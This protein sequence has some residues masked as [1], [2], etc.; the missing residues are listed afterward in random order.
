MLD[1][2]VI[3]LFGG[4]G[5][6]KST[7]AAHLFAL[8]KLKGINCELVTEYAK[9]RVWED[10][11]LK[12]HVAILAEQYT[13]LWRLQ[14]KVDYIITDSPLFLLQYYAKD[15]DGLFLDFSEEL[16][17]SF[18]NIDVFLNRV[19]KYNPKGRLQNLKDAKKIDS[20]FRQFQYDFEVDADDKAAE[21]I[22]NMICER[23]GK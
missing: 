7:T 13:R 4:P 12:N 9:E 8:M 16:F 15:V 17:H 5:T 22:Y 21:K 19:K 3:N 23:K 14:G 1:T 6:G 11:H 2:K 18:D 20:F 10:L